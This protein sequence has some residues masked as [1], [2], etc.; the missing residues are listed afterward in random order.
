MVRREVKGYSVKHNVPIN[1][2]I[3]ISFSLCACLYVYVHLY[4]DK[5]G[6]ILFDLPNNQ[7]NQG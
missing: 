4:P 3:S 2:S 7:S 1:L 5:G 6:K